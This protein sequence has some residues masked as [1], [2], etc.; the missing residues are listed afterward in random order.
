M[1]SMSSLAKSS[2][3]MTAGTLVSR[4]LGLVK[5]VLLTAA[6]GLAIGGA[7]DAFDVANKVPNNLYMLLAG[8]ILN[9][10]LVP[11]IV[12]A[13]KQADGGADYINRL[14]TLSILLLAGF[15][16]IA[17][18]AAPLLVRIYASP[19]W[20]AD[21]IALAV[22]F[23]YIS[24]PKIFFFGLYTMLGQVLNA[25]E[26]FGPY[27]WAPV[28]NNVVSIAGLG[29]FIFL[30]GPGDMGQHAVGT[31]DATKIWVIAGTGTLGVVAQALILIWPLKRIGFKY[32]PTFGF[33]GVGLGTAG[34]VA[35]WTFAA[36][37][38]GQLGFIV[39]SQVASTASSTGTE[40]TPSLA[41]YT[42]A[43]IT[44]M[45]PHS[46]VA[47]SLSTAL[48]TD[49]SQSAADH[50]DEKLVDTYTQGVRVVGFVNTFFTVAFIV[51]AAP[52]SMV[53]AGA[54]QTQAHAVGLIVIAMII[55]LI[56][57]SGMYLTQRVFYAYEDA[58][59]PF[60]IQVPQMIVQSAGVIASAFLPKQ[61]I[62]AGIGASMSVGYIFALAL[63]VWC[64]RKRL[65]S[66]P[67]APTLFAHIR[68]GL[69]GVVSGAVGFAMMWF[70]PDPMW[71]GRGRAFIVCAVIGC[72]MLAVFMLAA[73]LI[74][75]PEMRSLVTT[76]RA[77]LGR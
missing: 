18:L 62:V 68:F 75:V 53:M 10:V 31:W 54:N 34:K 58:R 72:V 7:A 14:L 2:A 64:L 61:Y 25:K 8:G 4:V 26:N 40:V 35:G 37:L 60:W 9:A 15:T 24:L 5:T 69:A 70:L 59:T 44:F 66:L 48:F 67:I 20:D 38:V 6:I 45:L 65:P 47:V 51:L 33:R 74:R 13:S 11:Q 28:L 22:A 41:A 50:N 77:K 1:A 39:T 56:P 30:F 36:V 23:A 32:T 46:L 42:A 49:L 29:L 17:T 21:K 43:Y 63:A 19:T 76:V 57:F 55:G 27:M 71:A 52:M 12:R 73:W 16:A 3:L